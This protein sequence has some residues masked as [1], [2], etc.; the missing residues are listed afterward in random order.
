MR[1]FPCEE[2][3]V[4]EKSFFS[5]GRL[6]FFLCARCKRF[7]A[8][9]QPRLTA[10]FLWPADWQKQDLFGKWHPSAADNNSSNAFARVPA[11]KAESETF[12]RRNMRDRF[13]F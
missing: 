6:I 9:A 5:V 2:S 11:D 1:V 7:A 13:A 3:R 12:Q 10:S 4:T 8:F